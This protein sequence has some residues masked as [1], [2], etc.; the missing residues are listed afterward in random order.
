MAL[1]S[2]AMTLNL[3]TLI[4][5]IERATSVINEDRTSKILRTYIKII[6]NDN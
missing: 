2:F 3:F 6:D 4:S 5:S 1:T